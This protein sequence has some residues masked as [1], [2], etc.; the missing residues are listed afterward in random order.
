MLVF[1]RLPNILAMVLYFKVFYQIHNSPWMRSYKCLGQGCIEGIP[2][3]GKTHSNPR[4]GQS[5]KEE[6]GRNTVGV[7][8]QF[9]KWRHSKALGRTELPSEASAFFELLVI[10]RTVSFPLLS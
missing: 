8:S 3:Q 4:A 2:R 1:H 10:L 6:L 9:Y 7:K 5:A